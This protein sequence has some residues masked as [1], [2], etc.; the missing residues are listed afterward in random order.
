MVV[1]ALSAVAGVRVNAPLGRVAAD[2]ET[3]LIQIALSAPPLA[4]TSYATDGGASGIADHSDQQ[5]V[6]WILAHP[7]IVGANIAYDMGVWLAEFPELGRAIFDAYADGRV[8]DILLNQLLIDIARG[9][10]PQ[11][12]G[13]DALH[14]KYGGAPLDK[15]TWRL[16]YG[17][18]RGIPI[19]TWDPGARK[20][21]IDDSIATLFVDEKQRAAF[22]QYLD[23]GPAQASA[24]FAL[25][26]MS[27]HGLRTDAEHCDRVIAYVQRVIDRA[28]KTAD[29]AGY[30][31]PDGGRTMARIK[32]DVVKAYRDGV[33][34]AKGNE[35]SPGGRLVPL[36]ETGAKKAAEALHERRPVWRLEWSDIVRLG[37]EKYISTD[38]ETCG[39]SGDPNLEAVQIYGTASTRI[40]KV[41]TLRLGALYPLQTRYDVIKETGR[42]SSRKPSPPLVGDNFQ[43][44]PRA[45]GYPRQSKVDGKWYLYNSP[46]GNFAAAG[47]FDQKKHAEEYARLV[48]VRGCVV[49]RPGFVLCSVDYDGAELHTLAQV[50]LWVLGYSRLAE[51]LNA[52]QD[53]HLLLGAERLLESPIGYA[54]AVKRLKAGDSAVKEA[55]QTAKVPNFGLPGGLGAATLID[56]AKAYGVRLTLAQAYALIAAWKQQWP[57]MEDYFAWVNG[58]LHDGIGTATQFISNRVRGNI[59]YTV[60]CNG[61]FQ[62]LAA[63]GAKSALLPLARECYIER[64]SPLYGSRPILFIHDEVIAELPEET[65]HLAAP[66]MAQIMVERFNRYTPDVPVTAEPALMRR[67][68]KNA[69]AVYDGGKKLI[70]WEPN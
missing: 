66:R 57:E 28:K 29:A 44:F 23:D 2:T 49:P 41:Q 30:L 32:A 38:E 36:S 13:L 60:M 56:Y 25:H 48:D 35:I 54:E 43:N 19:E 8:S 12:Q 21:S 42:T 50:C 62:G 4:C 47:P 11:P 67:W 6:A 58:Q 59:W 20:Y 34:D 55:R 33:R 17:Q 70:P 39:G 15:N 10:T 27:A 61:Y 5:I 1:P 69:K 63:D 16:R 31:K 3:A 53:P 22:G 45:S 9:R 64:D 14:Q 7:A 24:A 68:D 18:L 65:A 52:G 40:K 26:L 46:A 51:V 37:L